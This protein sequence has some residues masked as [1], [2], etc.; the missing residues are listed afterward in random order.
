[1]NRLSCA[2]LALSLMWMAPGTAAAAPRAVENLPVQNEGRIKPL[3][4]FARVHLLAFYGKR[5]LRDVSPVDWLL[6]LGV[7]PERAHERAVFTLRNPE[8]VEALGLP[9][10]DRRHYSFDE[11]RV[12]LQEH[13]DEI[14][15]IHR[16]PREETTLV[17]RQLSEVYTN[18]IRYLQIERS[19]SCLAPRFPV[20]DPDLAGLLGVEPGRPAAYVHLMLHL[21][22]IQERLTAANEKPEEEWTEADHEVVHLAQEMRVLQ[23]DS[24]SDVLR[25]IAPTPGG[26][27]D[28]WHAPWSLLES[29]HGL[30]AADREAMLRWADLLAAWGA[31]DE[32]HEERVAMELSTSMA[33]APH[34][35]PR[36]LAIESWY[37]R[38][39]LFY[40]SLA[41]YVLSFLLLAFSW[42]GKQR[43]LRRLA[44]V[45]L[46]I[47]IV[48][49]VGGMVLRMVIMGRPPVSTLYE[50]VIFV[51]MIG[52]IGGAW[53]E[54]ARRDGLGIFLGS[55]S[56]AVLHF[57]GIGYAAD[58]DTLG[59][60]VA[61]LNSNFWL[62]THVV[63]IT[64]G[65]G[66]SLVAG[67]A[68]HWYLVR[69]V[70]WPREAAKLDDVARNM[71]G[72][73]LVAVFFTLFGTIL[74]GIWADQSWG[75]F[76]GWD[77]KENG[78]LLI[79][80]WQLLL[81]HGV[82]T[83]MMRSVTFAAGLVF[84]NVI[85]ALAWFG[86]NLLNVGLHTYGFTEQIAWNLTIF[87]GVEMLF[88]LVMVPLAWR[89]APQ[90]R[91]AAGERR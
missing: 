63:T 65:Y 79:V 22:E 23:A 76:W 6:E 16:K 71:R 84:N 69:R 86:V 24:G 3:D 7:A 30:D 57:L 73:T 55:V 88:V 35:D 20:D 47:G 40:K 32:V 39:D 51:G 17:E 8:V 27:G 50:S 37:N 2:L 29:P 12:G 60:L 91:A 9:A 72:L 52:A 70:G 80:L 49:H 46:L 48:P 89:R 36:R 66:C 43:L 21:D 44:F 34:A 1:L 13:L 31:G 45:A 10:R 18:A 42:L 90:G 81:L 4:T 25:V 33:D 75:R 53:V 58:G 62:A 11:I 64:I 77:P 56:G 68:G 19:W 5:S 14:S 54:W 41:F 85:V 61:V 26:N 78:A 59:M 83:G 74:G 38:A 82:L 87:C 67:L 15:A 28:E